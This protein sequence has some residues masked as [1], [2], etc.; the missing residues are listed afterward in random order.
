MK[1]V[2]FPDPILR[3]RMPYFDFSQPPIDPEQL[4]K[5][6]I[7]LMFEQGGIGL[8]A[9][10]AGI[11]ARVFVMGHPDNPE[12]ARAFFNP[13]IISSTDSFNDMEEGCLSFPG[14]F[15]KVKRPEKIKAQWQNSK[16]E[17]QEGIFEGYD[18]KCF[19]HEFDHLEGIVFQDRISSLKWKLA[20][21]RKEKANARTK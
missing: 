10:Q 7:K 17:L 21:K 18:C 9:N 6:L 2:K 5:N 16:G 12:L 1:I 19:L 20:L 8:A 15:I 13:E 4:E 11:K 3:E 14:M